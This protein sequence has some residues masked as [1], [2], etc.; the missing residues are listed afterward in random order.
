MGER[1]V[2]NRIIDRSGIGDASSAS[3]CK[4]SQGHHEV[5][6]HHQVPR[7]EISRPAAGGTC[8]SM[9]RTCEC[10]PSLPDISGSNTSMSEFFQ[11]MMFLPEIARAALRLART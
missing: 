5:A 4:E 6:L 9:V 1:L 7:S 3:E 11:S 2:K 8:I 10:I